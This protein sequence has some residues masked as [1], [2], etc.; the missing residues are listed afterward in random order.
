MM[1]RDLRENAQRPLI[2]SGE[3][4][5]KEIL[6]TRSALSENTD[7]EGLPA[8]LTRLTTAKTHA[9]NTFTPLLR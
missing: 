7:E 6:K 1:Q 2:E 3:N 5:L 8:A 9:P 4:T